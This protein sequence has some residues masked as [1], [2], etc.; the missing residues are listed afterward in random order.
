MLIEWAAQAGLLHRA[1][2]GVKSDRAPLTARGIL[3]GN[4]GGVGGSDWR[5]FADLRLMDVGTLECCVDAD[6]SAISLLQ[7]HGED[8]LSE[9]C[10]ALVVL[11]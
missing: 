4:L 5:E 2:R 9:A 7:L 1:P 10:P 11:A 6:C 3:Q 8:G